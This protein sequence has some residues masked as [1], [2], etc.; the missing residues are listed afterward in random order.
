MRNDEVV[1]VVVVLVVIA[2]LMAAY[3]GLIVLGVTLAKRKNRSPHWMWFA[4]HP[5]GLL[6]TL[7]FMACL[8]P[9]KRCPNCTQNTQLQ[10][11]LCGICGYSYETG[12]MYARP[13]VYVPPQ[14]Y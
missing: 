9:L 6:I 8:P 1:Q 2:V 13:P 11:R 10:A 7:I 4:I 12:G 3:I 5:L 14:R